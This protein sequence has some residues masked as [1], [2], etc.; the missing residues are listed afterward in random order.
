MK[1]TILYR[2]IIDGPTYRTETMEWTGELNASDYRKIQVYKM[3][4]KYEYEE[5]CDAD[6]ENDHDNSDVLALNYDVLLEALPNWCEKASESILAG[7]Y[8]EVS[9]EMGGSAGCCL[10]IIGCWFEEDEEEDDEPFDAD[11]DDNYEAEC[12]GDEDVVDIVLK[13]YVAFGGGEYTEEQEWRTCLPR[14]FYEQYQAFITDN[15]DADNSYD[16]LQILFPEWIRREYEKIVHH[17]T[18]SFLSNVDPEDWNCADDM[19][20]PDW[21]VTDC[22]SV[23]ISGFDFEE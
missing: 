2:I 6:D 15:P 16:T 9:N 17:E 22:Y 13:Y 19:L 18:E 23:E 10:D 20:E 7:T 11:F 8:N 5:L 12:Y 3:Q 21:R 4:H 1:V 14:E